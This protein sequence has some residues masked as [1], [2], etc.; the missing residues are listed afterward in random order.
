MKEPMEIP[1]SLQ[2]TQEVR[3][4]RRTRN[5]ALYTLAKIIRVVTVPPVM[6]GTLIIFLSTLRTDVFA[7]FGESL[8]TLLFL[9]VIPVMAYPVSAVIPSIRAKGREGQRN[10]AF[11]LSFVGYSGGM[12][13]A[14][15]SHVSKPL[16]IV[17]GTYFLSVIVL[18]VMNKGLRIRAS[19][20]A[21][22]IA[23]PIGLVCYF[24]PPV[25]VVASLVLYGVIFWASVHMGRHTVKEFIWGSLSSP[26]SLALVAALVTLL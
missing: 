24:L 9:A 18:T 21:C 16:F 3:V 1:R 26:L 11:L 25:C 17:F 7:G 5:K 2:K 23:G 6:V 4:L 19:G 20:H 12:I 8:C 15:L 14:L 22:S 13:Y 10:L